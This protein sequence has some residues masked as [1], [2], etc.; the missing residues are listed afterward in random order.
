M[1]N[2]V[3]RILMEMEALIDRLIPNLEQEIKDETNVQT[4][5]ARE[6]RKD[7]MLARQE[8]YPEDRLKKV[9]SIYMDDKALLMVMKQQRWTEEDVVHTVKEV[10]GFQGEE[11]KAYRALLGNISQ[12]I[13]LLDHAK[14]PKEN[15]KTAE[16]LMKKNQELLAKIKEDMKKDI[17]KQVAVYKKLQDDRVLAQKAVNLLKKKES[18]EE[19]DRH[20]VHME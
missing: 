8:K 20:E 2:E 16:E 19:K 12:L 1:T 9:P 6:K 17:M 18:D 15:A 13:H 7:R 3:V 14:I 11:K 4:N 5:E 10:E